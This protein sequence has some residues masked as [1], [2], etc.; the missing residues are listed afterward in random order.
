MPST[1]RR[2]NTLSLK[3][4]VG[5]SHSFR[6]N[7]YITILY[8]KLRTSIHTILIRVTMLPSTLCHLDWLTGHIL[9]TAIHIHSLAS[10]ESTI[11]TFYLPCPR[12]QQENQATALQDESQFWTLACLVLLSIEIRVNLSSVDMPCFRHCC[13]NPD[14]G[15]RF[16]KL[17]AI[18]FSKA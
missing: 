8:I 9:K 2:F 4:R 5:E 6:R 18:F 11:F 12:R 15:H 1:R 7:A 16:P 13:C 3:L 10:I 14:H 17:P